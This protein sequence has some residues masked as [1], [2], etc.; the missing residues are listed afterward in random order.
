M[1]KL[2]AKLLTKMLV[3]EVSTTKP[4]TEMLAKAVLMMPKSMANPLAPRQNV[5]EGGVDDAE[6]DGEA[7]HRN[8]GDGGVDD[9]E[10]D[11]ETPRGNVGRRWSLFS[12]IHKT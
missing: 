7:P 6:V 2:M 11:G 5:G 3:K 1:P 12:S 8:V 4:L 9:T 10:V